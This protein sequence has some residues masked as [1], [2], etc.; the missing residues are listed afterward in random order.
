MLSVAARAGQV[1]APAA[2]CRVLNDGNPDLY[3]VIVYLS[4]HVDEFERIEL[5]D[6]GI[7]REEDDGMCAFIADTTLE[8]I[9]DHLDEYNEVLASAVTR[10]R[11][12]RDGA[13]AEDQR[14]QVLADEINNGLLAWEREQMLHEQR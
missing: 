7:V 1:S 11:Q 14:L 6:F 5:A 13:S 3:P 9:R 2:H 12:A 10:A 4:R 8:Y